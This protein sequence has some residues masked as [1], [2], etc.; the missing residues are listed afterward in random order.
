MRRAVLS[1]LVACAAV[2]MSS[3]A[4]SLS[5]DESDWSVNESVVALNPDGADYVI[6]NRSSV[7][8]TDAAYAAL[9]ALDLKNPGFIR[10][11]A[12]EALSFMYEDGDIEVNAAGDDFVKTSSNFSSLNAGLRYEMSLLIQSLIASARTGLSSSDIQVLVCGSCDPSS[13]DL[14]SVPTVTASWYDSSVAETA[15]FYDVDCGACGPGETESA[16]CKNNPS[17]KCATGC[18][19][20]GGGCQKETV[21]LTTSLV[22]LTITHFNLRNGL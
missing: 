7:S 14:S 4:Y 8:S 18:S 5:F 3:P 16:F 15:T 11:A 21:P 9:R 13:V 20:E 10:S 22:D 17:G 12:A 6:V 2:F 1:V 19:T